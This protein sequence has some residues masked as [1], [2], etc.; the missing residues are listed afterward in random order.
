MSVTMPDEEITCKEPFSH[1]E[2]FAF[3]NGIYRTKSRS[4]SWLSRCC[5]SFSFYRQFFWNVYRS[6]GTAKRGAYD[7]E[8]W[9]RTSFEVVRA[10]ESVGVQIEIHGVDNIR[11]LD[12]PC[13]FVGNHMSMFETIVFPSIIRPI[14]P[15][16]F[17]V[18]QSLLDYPFFR[19]ILRSRDPIAVTRQ[20]PREDLRKMM[21]VGEERIHQGISVVVFPQATRGLQFQPSQF[22]SIGVKLAR[23]A[24]VPIIP[25]ALKTDAWGNGKQLKDLGPIDPDKPVHIHFGPRLDV[26]G[27]GAD[28]QKE[29]IEFIESK[30]EEW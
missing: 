27:R 29:I 16:T 13:V 9:S 12:S 2:H 26:E 4:P 8:M 21:T 5:P 1:S 10:L 6:S 25:F 14:R 24:G 7:G 18:K 19:H 15:V 11:S 28:Q 23:K 17:V 22:N 20:N 30:L 3:E